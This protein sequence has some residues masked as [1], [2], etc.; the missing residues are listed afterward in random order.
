MV[1][2][3]SGNE[4]WSDVQYI[5]SRLFFM[6][7]LQTVSLLL[8]LLPHLYSYI[9]IWGFLGGRCHWCT[10]AATMEAAVSAYQKREAARMQDVSRKIPAHICSAYGVW[11]KR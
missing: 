11:W 10:G 1:A 3:F 6:V 4:H 7:L 8:F 2:R 5:H 9:R